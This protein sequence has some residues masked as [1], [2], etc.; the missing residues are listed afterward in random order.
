MRSTVFCAEKFMRVVINFCSFMFVLFCRRDSFITHRAFCDALAQESS[1]VTSSIMNNNSLFP[2]FLRPN[3]FPLI[4]TEEGKGHPFLISHDQ[5]IPSSNNDN[6]NPTLHFSTLENGQHHPLLLQ[7]NPNPNPTNPTSTP[8][9]FGLVGSGSG[10]LVGSCPAWES[11]STTSLAEN[12]SPLP[13]PPSSFLHHMMSFEEASFEEALNGIL[14]NGVDRDV[15]KGGGGG[16]GG[17]DGETRDFLGLRALASSDH[18]F[19][20]EINDMSNLNSSSLFGLHQ[21]HQTQTTF[22]RH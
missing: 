17:G 19:Q 20:D 9:G 15:V 16:G 14:M 13:L 10:P 12:S 1:T 4:K 8:I 21:N 22:W 6:S 5:I 3:L 18:I 11:S 2:S 7:Q